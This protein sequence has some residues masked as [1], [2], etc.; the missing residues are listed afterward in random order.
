[1]NED[2]HTNPASLPWLGRKLLW[3]DDKKNVDR[4]VYGLYT[5]CALLFVADFLYHK[6]VVF[7]IEKIPG[8]YALYGFIMC[9][10]LVICAKGLRV[11][12]K[13]REDYYAPNDVESENYPAD[14]LERID[15]DA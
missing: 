1:M 8:F 11:F 5:V 15:N 9:A 14:Q 10:A 7:G 6:H 3:L 2:K 13:R 12:L 4:I